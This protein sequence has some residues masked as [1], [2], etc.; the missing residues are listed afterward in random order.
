MHLFAMILNLF[1]SATH[2][3]IQASDT[4]PC[5]TIPFN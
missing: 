3:A 5:V 1:T 2:V 4:S